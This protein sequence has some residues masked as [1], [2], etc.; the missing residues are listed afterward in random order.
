MHIWKSQFLFWI[1]LVALPTTISASSN[2]DPLF[3][4]DS[5]GNAVAVWEDVTSGSTSIRANTFVSGSWGTSQT[6]M[7]GGTITDFVIIGV[8]AVGG[9]ISAVVVWTDDSGLSDGNIVLYSSMLTSASSTWTSPN[10]IP[11]NTNETVNSDFSLRVHSDGTVVL[12][13]TSMDTV[14]FD[15]DVKATTSTINGSNTWTT[16]VIIS[17]P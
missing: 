14:T 7:S 6:I 13:Y 11:S 3:E 12:I 17:S 15:Q 16:P 2:I 8:N 5:N 9:D 4:R 1:C 10:K